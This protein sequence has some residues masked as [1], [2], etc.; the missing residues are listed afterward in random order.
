M[1]L[2]TIVFLGGLAAVVTAGTGILKI[3]HGLLIGAALVGLGFVLPDP[4]SAANTTAG[5]A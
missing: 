2:R 1:N 4:G 5:A 3:K